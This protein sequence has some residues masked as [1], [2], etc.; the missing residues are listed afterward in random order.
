MEQ[1]VFNENITTQLG[2]RGE[3]GVKEGWERGRW[4]GSMVDVYVEKKYLHNYPK[5]EINRFKSI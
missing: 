4:R 5:K 2:R 1:H 3:R